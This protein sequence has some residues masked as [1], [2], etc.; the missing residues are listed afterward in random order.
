[1]VLRTPLGLLRLDMVK[2]WSLCLDLAWGGVCPVRGSGTTKVVGDD[3][4][5]A[6]CGDV[7]LFWI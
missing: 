7:W 3:D 5:C 2:V 4:G 6:T 1:M